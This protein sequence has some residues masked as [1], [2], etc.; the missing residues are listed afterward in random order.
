MADKKKKTTIKVLALFERANKSDRAMTSGLLKF[1]ERIAEWEIRLIDPR[2]DG[3]R[4][5]IRHLS[6]SWTPDGIVACSGG[7]SQL[8]NGIFD[9]TNPVRIAIDPPNANYSGIDGAVLIDNGAIAHAAIELFSRRNL[10][11]IFYVGT[12][13]PTDAHHSKSRESALKIRTAGKSVFDAFMPAD[14]QPEDWLDELP[15]L[16][17]WLS[18]LPK[19]CGV[20][21]YCD[22]RAVQVLDAC[23]IAHISVPEQIALL[24]VDN[25]TGLCENL[26]PSLSSIMPDFEGAGYIAGKMLNAILETGR[27]LHKPLTRHYGTK[28]LVERESTQDLR[29][30]GRLVNAARIF[31]AAHACDGIGVEDTAR[32]LNVSRRLLELRFSE[33]AGRTIR[34]EIAEIRL[35]NVCK[36]LRETSR[37]ASDIAWASGFGTVAAMILAFKRRFG[38]TPGKWREK[39]HSP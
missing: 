29:G 16:A 13:R 18:G 10:D 35:Q 22:E 2:S 36:L 38:D 26:Q 21:A 31:I 20:M 15:E 27:R 8:S 9:S 17:K 34:E 1:G 25:D 37:T 32:A 12:A 33:I 39:L 3:F 5:T 19:P 7:F 24:G 30:G 28:T 6:D 11:N 4:S 14:K 23:R